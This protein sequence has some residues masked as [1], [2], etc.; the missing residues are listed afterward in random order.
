MTNRY[1]SQ[2]DQRLEL[3]EENIKHLIS[4]LQRELKSKRKK[5][6]DYT[7]PE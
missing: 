4:E 5:I 2:Y 3:N 6:M 1:G 7:R